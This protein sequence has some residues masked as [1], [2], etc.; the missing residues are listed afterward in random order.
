M[1]TLSQ[2]LRLTAGIRVSDPPPGGVSTPPPL[3]AGGRDMARGVRQALARPSRELPCLR[4]SP[5]FSVDWADGTP[6]VPPDSIAAKLRDTG[7]LGTK[8]GCCLG[9][10]IVPAACI[11]DRSSQ[12]AGR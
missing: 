5:F 10:V 11:K 4:P 2:A 12:A 7:L 9:T 3:K 8:S 1:E 6:A